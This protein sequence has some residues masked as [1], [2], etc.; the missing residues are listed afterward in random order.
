[1]SLWSVKGCFRS[2]SHTWG[3]GVLNLFP[4]SFKMHESWPLLIKFLTTRLKASQMR[5][6]E[7]CMSQ[8]F[9]GPGYIERAYSIYFLCVCTIF[10]PIKTGMYTQFNAVFRK[11]TKISIYVFFFFNHKA[12]IFNHIQFTFNWIDLYFNCIHDT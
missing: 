3:Q 6:F 9:S 7:I 11:V 8:Y 5:W 10:S 12:S 1:M 4:K 2:F